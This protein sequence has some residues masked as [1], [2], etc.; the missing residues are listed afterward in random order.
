MSS[1]LAIANPCSRN[2]VSAQSRSS[3]LTNMPTLSR[4]T[5]TFCSSINTGWPPDAAVATN[6]DIMADIAGIEKANARHRRRPRR[7]APRNGNNCPCTAG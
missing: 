4:S 3:R 1:S 7:C 5:S 2:G 6:V